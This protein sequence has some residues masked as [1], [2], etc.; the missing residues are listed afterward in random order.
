MSNNNTPLTL[1][2]SMFQGGAS[3]TDNSKDWNSDHDSKTD[4]PRVASGGQG[5]WNELPL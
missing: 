1:V 3:Q 4:S 5:L 2:K